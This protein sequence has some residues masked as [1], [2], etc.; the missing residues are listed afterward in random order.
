MQ[1]VLY[2]TSL[3]S[4]KFRHMERFELANCARDQ[5]HIPARFV[6][7]FQDPQMSRLHELH[8]KPIFVFLVGNSD[9]N[10]ETP[11]QTWSNSI[12]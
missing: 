1:T 11:Q 8:Q 10:G 3:E 9:S 6:P 7:S 12:P 4:P 2:E 5:A